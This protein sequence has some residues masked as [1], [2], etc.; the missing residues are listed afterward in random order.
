MEVTVSLKLDF[1]VDRVAVRNLDEA[2]GHDAESLEGPSGFGV[3]RLGLP[4]EVVHNDEMANEEEE[5]DEAEVLSHLA[6]VRQLWVND[7]AATSNGCFDDTG[8]HDDLKTLSLK[9][10]A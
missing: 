2:M 9:L 4:I 5:E 7:T 10:L 1:T 6:A 3:I 8:I